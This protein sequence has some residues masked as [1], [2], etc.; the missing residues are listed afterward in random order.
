VV[1]GQGNRFKCLAY[2]VIKNP[3]SRRHSACLAH[4]YETLTD[5]IEQTRP[6]AVAIEGIFFSKNA[7]TAV[8]LGQARGAVLTA[9]ARAGLAVYEYS[10]RRVKQ[11]VVGSGK[12]PKEQVARM[13]CSMTGLAEPPPEDAADALAIAICHINQQ[14]GHAV[15]DAKQI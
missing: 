2:D 5:F 13:I 3:A 9:C 7:R 8:I 12:A 6:D 15:I 11:A 1:E 10:P 4:L 14:T